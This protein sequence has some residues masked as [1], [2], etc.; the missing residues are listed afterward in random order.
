VRERMSYRD[1]SDDDRKSYESQV[2]N[3]FL[4]SIPPDLSGLQ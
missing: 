4:Q 1:M 3:F 2:V